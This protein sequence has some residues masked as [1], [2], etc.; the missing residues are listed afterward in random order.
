MVVCKPTNYNFE[1]NYITFICAK[2]EWLMMMMMVQRTVFCSS[3][4]GRIG[5]PFCAVP[6]LSFLVEMMML[7]GTVPAVILGLSGQT[8]KGWFAIVVAAM[9][10]RRNDGHW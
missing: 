10:S 5:N 2:Y 3:H 7:T 9:S 8:A 4:I 6:A 1:E